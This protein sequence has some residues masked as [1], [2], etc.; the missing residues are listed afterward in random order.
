MGQLPDARTAVREKSPDIMIRLIAG[1]AAAVTVSGGLLA[2]LGLTAG[3]AHANPPGCSQYSAC[4]CPGQPM[5]GHGVLGDWDNGGCHDYHF[6]DEHFPPAPHMQGN[7]DPNLATPAAPLL[8]RRGFPAG[9]AYAG[10]TRVLSLATPAA[11][12][13]RRFSAARPS[14]AACKRV[15]LICSAIRGRVA[16]ASVNSVCSVRIVVT[17]AAAWHTR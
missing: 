4:W 6:S 5:P 9:T 17:A 8:L 13:G 11:R 16:S 12:P 2:G 10:G 1:C 3:T 14:A 7:K 15:Y